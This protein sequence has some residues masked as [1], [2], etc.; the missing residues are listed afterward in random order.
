MSELEQVNGG[1]G[2]KK[3]KEVFYHWDTLVTGTGTGYDDCY[4]SGTCTHDLLSITVKGLAAMRTPSLFLGAMRCIMRIFLRGSM[5]YRHFA[6]T[7]HK[8]FHISK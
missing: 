7:L 2:C 1:V 8:I 3:K 4:D 5:K 6:K